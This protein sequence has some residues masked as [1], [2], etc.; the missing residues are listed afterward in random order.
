MK[1]GWFGKI[2]R[3]FTVTPMDFRWYQDKD[4]IAE[5]AKLMEST[6]GRKELL[7]VASFFS[8]NSEAL[9]HLK[10]TRIGWPQVTQ[11]SCCGR[12]CWGVE[13]RTSV[14]AF[15]GPCIFFRYMNF[16]FTEHVMGWGQVGIMPN[17]SVAPLH[18]LLG[19]HLY[20]TWSSTSQNMSWGGAV[21]LGKLCC[22]C[23]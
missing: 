1:R 2:N 20:A 5:H 10:M 12:S 16:Y 4:T 23:T 17:G 22:Q 14:L 8:R 21:A 7:D 6:R 19:F 3:K 18:D 11:V 13:N 9:K 15:F